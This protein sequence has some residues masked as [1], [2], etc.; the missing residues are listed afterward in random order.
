MGI[1]YSFL[2]IV[3]SLFGHFLTKYLVEL[4]KIATFVSQT[5][6]NYGNFLKFGSSIIPSYGRKEEILVPPR[7]L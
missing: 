7:H 3:F 4:H 1:Q 2:F 6:K 5:G